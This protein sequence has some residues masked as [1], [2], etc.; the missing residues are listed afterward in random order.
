MAAADGRARLE[1]VCIYTCAGLLGGESWLSA[2]SNVSLKMLNLEAK[3][4]QL[5]FVCV[6]L[7]IHG[8]RCYTL[9]RRNILYVGP[10]YAARVC[11]LDL[12]MRLSSC[13][14]LYNTVYRFNHWIDDNIKHERYTLSLCA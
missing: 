14:V 13:Y 4:M 10:C 7:M 5:G 3:S 11:Q 1:Q 2:Q 9:K 6:D 8:E 12:R